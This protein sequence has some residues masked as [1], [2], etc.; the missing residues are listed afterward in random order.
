[1][2]CKRYINFFEN[3]VLK[4]ALCVKIDKFTLIKKK[5]ENNLREEIQQNDI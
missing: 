4:L 3:C 2:I 1:M 5:Q